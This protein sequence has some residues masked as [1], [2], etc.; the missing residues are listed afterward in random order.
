MIYLFWK[1]Y[2]GKI[3]KHTNISVISSELIISTLSIKGMSI[4]LFLGTQLKDYVSFGAQSGLNDILLCSDI[5][6][7]DMRYVN[8][9]NTMN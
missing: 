5:R 1:L 8:V 2:L 9:V 4:P 7:G 3:C 6:S